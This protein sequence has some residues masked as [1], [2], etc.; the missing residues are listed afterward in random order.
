MLHCL[1]RS[2]SRAP[3]AAVGAVV[4]HD[5]P[6][7]YQVA[8]DVLE[9]SHRLL[10]GVGAIDV[11]ECYRPSEID[12]PPEEVCERFAGA[13]CGEETIR[14]ELDVIGKPVLIKQL[15]RG[16]ECLYHHGAQIIKWYGSSRDGLS[17]CR[18]L[19]PP[20]VNGKDRVLP[21]LHLE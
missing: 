20:I 21:P 17:E 12:L 9:I 8:G 3:V 4:E 14:V 11:G 16:S 6:A 15:D 10:V 7:A 1:L 18:V 13:P 19:E 2:Q 5:E